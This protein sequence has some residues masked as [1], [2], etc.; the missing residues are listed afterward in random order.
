MVEGTIM[1]TLPAL[2]TAALLIVLPRTMADGIVAVYDLEGRLSEGGQEEA[3]LF[4]INMNAGRPLTHYDLVRSLA[5]VPT[6]DKVKGVVLD[7]DQAALGL[8]QVQEVRRLLQTIREADKDVWLYADALDLKTALVGSA[9]NK[10]VLMPEGNVSLT[11]LY[12]ERMYFKGLF[13]K[14]GLDVDVVHIGD[15]KAAGEPF[16]RT[17]PSE[18][19]EKQM[20]ELYDALWSQLLSQIAGGREIEEHSLKAFIDAGS[21][22]PQQAL[23]SGLVDSLQYRT[24]FIAKVRDHYGKGTRFDREYALP[25]TGP[26]DMNSMFDLFSLMFKAGKPKSRSKP[27]LAVVVLD[28]AITNASIAPVRTEVIKAARNENCRG[29]VLRVNSPGG[30]AL[31][32]EVLWEATDEFKSDGR[33]FVVSMGG[34]AA[35][36]G[37]YVA[38]GADRI[39]AEPGTITGSIGV[40]GMKLALGGTMEH[41]GLTTHEIKRGAHADLMNTT[42]PFSEDERKLVRASMLGIY[43][44]FKKR[45]SDGRGDRIVGDLETLAGGRVYSGSQALKVGLVDELGGLND[46]IAYLAEEAELEDPDVF[47]TPEPKDPFAGLFADPSPDRG[48]EFITI[49]QPRD[50]ASAF[51]NHLSA[52]PAMELLDEA[53]RQACLQAWHTLHAARQETTLLLAPTSSITS[54]L[55]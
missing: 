46:A 33:P 29:L 1:K 47:M 32:S 14:I 6:N 36:G 20:N 5:T 8:A 50:P 16:S 19:A 38:A 27:Y 28:A 52:N 21:R 49:S 26:P 44:T 48:D 17:G 9:A 30:S 7:L 39:F 43:D 23:E 55:R 40:V 3:S 2:L 31:A 10:F 42:R 4:S 12:G 11:G 45:V 54:S 18:A 37:Y 24:D 53:K 34:V 25:D 13:D 22:T 35:S 51:R 41:L 15:F